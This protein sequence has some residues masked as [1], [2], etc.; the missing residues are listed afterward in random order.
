MAS[1]LCPSNY[2]RLI[3]VSYGSPF[4]RKYIK[5]IFTVSLVCMHTNGILFFSYIIAGLFKEI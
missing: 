5:M 1:Y 4:F 3:L 2:M